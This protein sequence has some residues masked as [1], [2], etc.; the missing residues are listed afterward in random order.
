MRDGLLNLRELETL[1]LLTELGPKYT[2]NQ[3]LVIRDLVLG[4]RD[5]Q[6]HIR[7]A[8]PVIIIGTTVVVLAVL[9]WLTDGYIWLVVITVAL[10]G[11]LAMFSRKEMLQEKRN[12]KIRE[13]LAGSQVTSTY[14]VARVTGFDVN[15]VETSIVD[16]I[17]TANMGRKSPSESLQFLRNAKFDKL[18]HKVTLDPQATASRAAKLGASASAILDRFAPARVEPKPDWRCQYCRCANVGGA[19]ACQKCGAGRG[20]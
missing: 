8:R 18:A 10:W 12:E 11:G 1:M 17:S 20:E 16:M 6:G 19:V 7:R 9:T 14:D 5:E 3:L 13:V 4:P 15:D 2:M